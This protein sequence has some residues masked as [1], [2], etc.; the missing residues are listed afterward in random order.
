ME[1][2]RW[3]EN[4]TQVWK[5]G[6]V[7]AKDG[8]RAE[9][10]ELY[11]YHKGEIRIRVSGKR[12][13][14]LLTTVR[15]ELDKIHASYERLRYSTLVPCNCATCNGSQTPHFYLLHVLHRALDNNTDQV[16]CQ[17]SFQMV[18]VKRLIDDVISGSTQLPSQ[19]KLSQQRRDMLS[20]E[21]NLRY[22]N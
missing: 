18:S 4:Q 11:C 9:V 15:H 14:D 21:L 12:P 17:S 8:A 13:R 6:V 10:T 3:I 2:H 22:E 20:D 16:Q 7:L 5:T 1:M 19:K